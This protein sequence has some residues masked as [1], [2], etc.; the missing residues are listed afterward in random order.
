MNCFE[1]NKPWGLVYV[2]TIGIH[3]IEIVI[4]QGKISW[5]IEYSCMITQI[6]ERCVWLLQSRKI[7]IL[8]LSTAYLDK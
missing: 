8:R 3:T 7:L 4:L 2:A 6:P 1:K 5:S